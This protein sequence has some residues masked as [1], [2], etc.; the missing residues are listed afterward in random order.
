MDEA[1]WAIPVDIRA[2]YAADVPKVPEA[3]LVRNFEAVCLYFR[4][5]AGLYTM[6]Q[7]LSADCHPRRRSRGHDAA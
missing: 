5:G 3:D 7:H 6:Y 2:D 1:G 4:G